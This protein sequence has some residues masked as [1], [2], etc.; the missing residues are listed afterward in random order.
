MKVSLYSPIHLENWGPDT[1][2]KTGIGGSETCH[3][4]VAERLAARGHDVTSYAPVTSCFYQKGV[5]WAPYK[6]AN[7]YGSREAFFIFRDVQWFKNS[8][9]P[10]QHGQRYYFVAQDVDY[11]WTEEAV[12]RVDR[13]LC[14][15]KTHRDFTSQKYPI[16]ADRISTTTNGIRSEVIRNVLAEGLPRDPHR[17]IYASSPDRGLLFILKNWKR[18]REFCPEAN[19]RVF[20]GFDNADKLGTPELRAL[21]AQCLELMKQPGISWQGR[22]GQMDL[23]R[24]WAQS[25]VWFY[26]SDWPETSCITCMDAQALG[27]IPITNRYWAVGENILAQELLTDG[28]PQ[29]SPLVGSLLLHRLHAALAGAYNGYRKLLMSKAQLKYDWERVVDD[30]EAVLKADFS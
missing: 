19:L 7:A 5:K 4:E 10:R 1:P 9:L 17:L 2:W 15:C 21:K 12:N 18:I 3:I 30:Y 6:L 23:Y 14:L 24:E 16:I 22:I 8:E 27:C 29:K 25:S 11:Q 26:P 13:Y 28:L 20:Y